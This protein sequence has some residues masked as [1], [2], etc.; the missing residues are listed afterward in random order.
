MLIV[1]D[2]CRQFIS[3]NL[4]YFNES[5]KILTSSTP[6][7]KI[8]VITDEKDQVYS[9]LNPWRLEIKELTK[10]DAIDL[11]WKICR[12]NPNFRK[13]YASKEKIG[14][15]TFFNKQLTFKPITYR[16]LKG[17]NFFIR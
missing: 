15:Q 2:N 17:H 11:L 12:D 10:K 13:N 9:K 5:L 1:L 8:I 3:E 7:L 16:S 4:E 14:E 6:N